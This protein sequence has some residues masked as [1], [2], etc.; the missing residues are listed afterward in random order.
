[1][2][3]MAAALMDQQRDVR[4]RA[5]LLLHRFMALDSAL[6][7]SFMAHAPP[8]QVVRGVLHI[9]EGVG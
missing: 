9:W 2:S 4:D 5:T 7:R 1:M 3:R 8:P 6:L